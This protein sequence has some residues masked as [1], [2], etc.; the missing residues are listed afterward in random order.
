MKNITVL[1]RLLVLVSVTSLLTAMSCEDE[2]RYLSIYNSSDEDIYFKMG[3]A[4]VALTPADFQRPPKHSEMIEYEDLRRLEL[5]NSNNPELFHT[6]LIFKRSTI[7]NH[8][9]QEIQQQNLYDARY[10]LAVD[11]VYHETHPLIYTGN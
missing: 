5:P 10:E 8:S 7:E 3:Y 11:D 1:L 4:D 9:W 6:L 2:I